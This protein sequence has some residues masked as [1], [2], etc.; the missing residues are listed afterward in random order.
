MGF[1]ARI[2][3]LVLASWQLGQPCHW[4]TRRPVVE[5][6]ELRHRQQ[7]KV[8][9]YEP[10]TSLRRREQTASGGTPFVNTWKKWHPNLQR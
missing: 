10:R 3:W 8:S 1:T 6:Q 7:K 9:V 4:E 5:V 2:R